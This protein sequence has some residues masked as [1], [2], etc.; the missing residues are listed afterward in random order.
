MSGIVAIIRRDDEVSHEELAGLLETLSYRGRDGTGSVAE[1]TVGLG[2]QRFQ[3]LPEHRCAEQPI[4]DDDVSLVVDG[5][6][7]NREELLERL[8]GD[9]EDPE[10]PSDPELMLRAYRQWGTD[11][12]SHLVGPLALVL[13]DRERDRVLCAR[14]KT[15]LRHLY[16]A[17]VGDE[18]VVASEIS[19]IHSYAELA[20]AVNEGTV[21]RLLTDRLT[22]SGETFFDGVR[23]L[24]HGTYL[25]VTDDGVETTRYWSPSDASL[26]LDPE[27]SVGDELRARLGKAVAARVTGRKPL[28]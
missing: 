15:G 3:T 9:G 12:L 6:L 20:P 28:A 17:Q 5:R 25:S 21:G 13:W 27:Q 19:S 11:F 2:F 16:Y 4:R 23:K 24:E 8:D 26:D 14:D 22:T 7:D 18:V 10:G 1:G